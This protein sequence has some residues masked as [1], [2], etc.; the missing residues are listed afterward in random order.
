M[1]VPLT[2]INSEQRVT[3]LPGEQPNVGERYGR[4]LEFPLTAAARPYA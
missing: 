1:T 2:E 3:V 4:F